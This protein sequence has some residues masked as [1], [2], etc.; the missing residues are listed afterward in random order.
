[1]ADPQALDP[2]NRDRYGI[3][4]LSNC[5]SDSRFDGDQPYNPLQLQKPPCIDCGDA[6]PAFGEGV[7]MRNGVIGVWRCH[8]CWSWRQQQART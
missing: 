6:N 2:V 3:G 4:S 7:N 1:M 8:G 5:R